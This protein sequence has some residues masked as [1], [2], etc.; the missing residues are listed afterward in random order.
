MKKRLFICF[1]ILISLVTRS[2]NDLVTIR[3]HFYRASKSSDSADSLLTRLTN[4]QQNNNYV[5][6]GYKGMAQLLVCYH[7]YNPYT[8]FKYF[9]TGKESL[10]KAIK[11]D[12]ENI[13]LRFLRLSV[14]L[15]APVF[16]GYFSN[17]DDD[18]KKIFDGMKS[19]SDKDL[20]DR[21][22]NYTL[23]AKKLTEP[24]KQKVREAVALNTNFKSHL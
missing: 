5:L 17:I 15:N 18:K 16:L 19:I 11:N 2:N 4:D 23:H 12:P 6:M 3:D 13:E 22:V 1:Y 10:E 14:Q 7:S 20:F 24:E 8:K 21:I 9:L